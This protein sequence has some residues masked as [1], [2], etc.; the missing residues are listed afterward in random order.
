MITIN[1]NDIWYYNNK[2][3]VDVEGT[4]YSIT[5]EI[6]DKQDA[7]IT[8]PLPKQYIKFLIRKNSKLFINAI[9]IHKNKS[10]DSVKDILNEIIREYPVIE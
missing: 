10:K 8:I 5:V 4:L 1:S 3:H 6:N 9:N 2:N 7:L